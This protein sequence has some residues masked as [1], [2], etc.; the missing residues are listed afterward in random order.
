MCCM[1]Q[2]ESENQKRKQIALTGSRIRRTA[3]RRPS[4][5]YRLRLLFGDSVCHSVGLVWVG[6]A[7]RRSGS[8][9]RL[10]QYRDGRRWHVDA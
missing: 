7:I 2:A 8:A 9:F 5:N 3:G 10:R 4:D 1:C 6:G